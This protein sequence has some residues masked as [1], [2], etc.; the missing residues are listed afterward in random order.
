V[1]NDFCDWYLEIV[2]PRLL[3]KTDE[4]ASAARGT[5]V[6]VLMDSLAMLHPFT[7]FLTEVLWKALHETLGKKAP[8]LMNSTWPTGDG[9]AHDERAESQMQTIQ[10]IV[11]A[12]RRVRNLTMVGERQRLVALIAA[13]REQDRAVLKDH[14]ATVRGLAF[15]ESYEVDKRF[16]RPKGTAVA[17]AG[18]IE[19]FVHLGD[20]VD[21]EK[22]VDVLKKRAD[23]V[24]QGITSADAKLSNQ[25]FLERA[26]PDVV[27]DERTRR[28]EMTL[29]LEMLERNV[30]GL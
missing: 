18:A 4:S 10:D 12:V 9:V 14:S 25:G 28:G 16:D 2:K 5:L 29:E 21:L 11:Q 26:D 24:R 15:L 1:W 6:R 7:P 19:V 17:T 13:P 8:M 22:L 3:S 27:E 20:D 30:A 23:K